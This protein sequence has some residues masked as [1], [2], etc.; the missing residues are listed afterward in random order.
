MRARGK[1]RL[2]NIYPDNKRSFWKA[3]LY[4][5]FILEITSENSTSILYSLFP[6]ATSLCL[7]LKDN[8]S[9]PIWKYW[10]SCLSLL[11]INYFYLDKTKRSEYLN[12]EVKNPGNNLLWFW[13]IK[14]S[15]ERCNQLNPKCEQYHRMKNPSSSINK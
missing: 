15:L 10:Y 9:S 6:P 14:E 2:I 8:L 3:L 11:P 5:L 4:E 1:M 12:P 13:N 7:S